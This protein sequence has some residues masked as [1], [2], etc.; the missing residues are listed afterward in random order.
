MMVSVGAEGSGLGGYSYDP[1]N[2]SDAA[3]RFTVTKVPRGP[4]EI[5]C[6][7]QDMD[8]DLLWLNVARTI[9]GGTIDLGDLVVV[10][11]R[12]KDGEPAGKLGVTL[13][14]RAAGFEIASIDANGSAARSELRVGDVITSVDG[15]DYATRDSDMMDVMRARAGTMLALGLARGVTVNVALAAP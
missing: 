5:R 13:E 12:L 8:S 3:G 10:R 9:G 6:M 2:I 1:D 15:L 11:K 4:I 14:R 7:P